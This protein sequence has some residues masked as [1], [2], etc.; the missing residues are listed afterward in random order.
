MELELPKPR[1]R[2]WR[3]VWRRARNIHRLA[4]P[5]PVRE[6]I[7]AIPPHEELA[8]W[9]EYGLLEDFATV[10]HRD[11]TPT[12]RRHWVIAL[13]GPQHIERWER[14][15]YRFDR[16]TW[17]Y[18]ISRARIILPNGKQQRARVTNRPC[19]R[20][21]YSRLI[22]VSFSRLAP[23]VIVDM[24][25]QQDNF[26]PF[27][28]CPGVWGNYL[29]QTTVP[30]RQRR[31][32]L[33]VAHPF[34]GR[35]QLHHGA[36]APVERQIHDYHVWTWDLRDVPGIE[37]DQTTPPLCEFAPCIDLST[38]P[39]W[40]PVARYY[41]KK[42]KVPARL[43]LKG[44]AANLAAKGDDTRARVE[45]AYN[46]VA[47][48][49]RYGRPKE[50]SQDWAIRPLGAVVEELRGDCKDKSALLVALLREFHVEARVALI[51]T[52]Q[53]GRVPLLPGARF[54]HAVVRANIDGKVIWF[55]PVGTY[56]LGQL[57]SY[58][59]GVQGL[60]LDHGEP[61]TFSIPPATPAD[62]RVERVVRGRLEADGSYRVDVR[63]LARG[64]RAAYWRHGLNARSA[65]TRERVL[66]Q[67]LGGYLPSA[68]ITNV[69]VEHLDDLNG[70]LAICH[71]AVIS[72]LARCIENLLLLRMPWLEPIRDNGFFAA[73]SRPQ[74]LAVPIHSVSDR[75]EL[76]LPS[77]FSG[78]GLPLERLEECEWGRY[79]CRVATDNG[80]LRCERT[81]EL[82]GGVIPPERYAEMRLF[83]GACIDGDASDI[84]LDYAESAR[85][86]RNLPHTK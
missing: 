2:L 47:R 36:P 72:R 11:G 14:F 4:P 51:L 73:P 19:D 6:A 34:A 61:Q 82:R 75:H 52:A 64:D 77:G 38:L 66:C 60:I 28:D 8:H 10:L 25:D 33:A 15:E 22:E 3:T 32:T 69:T 63:M 74:P 45:A 84:V 55:D 17:K 20:W 43:E 21:G 49:V 70:D 41:L 29:L 50:N 1:R 7:T 67:H 23:G 62:H 86:V 9:G 57:P 40:K 85:S 30:C 26:T 37:W 54:N 81:F 27:E 53:A 42:L 48:D 76:D 35:V 78:Y 44:L 58:A 68:Q 83:T 31:I 59:Q 56:T 39:N 71:C 18:T 80:V 5:I 79:Q 13:H 65:A 12:F 46:Y 24:E 16:R